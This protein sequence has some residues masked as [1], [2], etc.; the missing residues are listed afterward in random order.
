MGAD[1]VHFDTQVL[2][3]GNKGEAGFCSVPAT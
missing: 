1:A 2:I 3:F